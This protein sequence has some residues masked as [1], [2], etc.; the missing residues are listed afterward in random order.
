ML[1]AKVDA[2]CPEGNRSEHVAS[3]GRSKK[4]NSGHFVP[5]VDFEFLLVNAMILIGPIGGQ[6]VPSQDS[7]NAQKPTTIERSASAPALHE[8]RDQHGGKGSAESDAEQIETAAETAAG[9]PHPVGNHLGISRRTGGFADPDQEPDDGGRRCHS[10]P[11]G[12]K[13]ARSYRRVAVRIDHHEMAAINIFRGPY[14]SD[15]YP[16]RT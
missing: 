6:K 10:E 4:Q 9:G 5:G 2:C 3:S 15:R 7:D 11:P 14:R 1:M 8:E 16:P 13:K 12:Q